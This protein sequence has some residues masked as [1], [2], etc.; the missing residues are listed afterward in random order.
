MA[1]YRNEIKYLVSEAQI[2]E[3]ECRLGG[4]L[5]ADSH[6]KAVGDAGSRSQ[7]LLRSLY[8]DD[9][10]NS[11][12]EENLSGCDPREKWRIRI[13]GHSD[14]T[15][16]LERKAKVRGKTHKDRCP[17]TRKQTMALI[18]GEDVPG[19]SQTYRADR[20]LREFMVK[21][22][23][24]LF[25]PAVI[26]VYERIPYVYRLGNVRITLDRNISSSHD[27][28]NFFDERIALRPVLPAGMHLLEVKYDEFLPTF[29]Y[30]SLQME[31]L[32]RTAFSKYCLCRRYGM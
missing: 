32:R 19:V 23:L 18:H 8:F 3:L 1:Y 30:Q 27:F 31:G 22:N 28:D 5:Q 4:V 7:Y 11:C 26:T 17:L 6:A 10:R 12:Y 25:S 16:Y 14:E 2:V 29:I 15:I 13:Y 9:Y 24:R 20:L 21:K